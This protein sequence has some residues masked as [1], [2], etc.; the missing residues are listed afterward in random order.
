MNGNVNGL[1]RSGAG[2]IVVLEARTPQEYPP[3]IEPTVLDQAGLTF[4]PELLLVRTG[5]PTEFRNSDET[6]HNVHVSNADTK[7]AAF[8]VAIPTGGKYTYT[9]RKDGFYHVGCDIHPAMAADI[10]AT[11]SPFATVAESDG[12]FA[13]TDVPPGAYT[14]H[15][16]SSRGRSQQDVEIRKGVNELRIE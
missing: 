3:Q 6:L 15:T 9:F 8:N 12:R 14:V 16:F 10:F 7:E 13:F 4:S 11:S 5:Q 2:A 1:L